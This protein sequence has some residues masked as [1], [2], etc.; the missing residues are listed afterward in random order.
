MYSEVKLVIDNSV[1]VWHDINKYLGKKNMNEMWNPDFPVG[2]SSSVFS[3]WHDKGIHVLDD[4]FK[5]NIML[6][7]QQLQETFGIPKEHFFGYLQI[8]QSWAL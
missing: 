2:I 7:F 6:S 1:R 4:L 3:S 5:D 8:R